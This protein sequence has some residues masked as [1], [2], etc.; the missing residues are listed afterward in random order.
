M[1]LDQVLERDCGVITG[2]VREAIKDRAASNARVLFWAD[3][4]YRIRE[5]SQVVIKAN[6]YEVL[7]C[8]TPLP[9]ERVDEEALIRAAQA[10]RKRSGAP[11][12]VTR[13]ADGM[14][15]SDPLWTRIPGVPIAG[16]IDPTGAGD[17][18][19]AG[20][21]L[22]LCAGAT[23]PE[24]ALV[25]NLVAAITIRQIGTTGTAHPDQLAAALDDWHAASA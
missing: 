1:I 17:S 4:R 25:G 5:F 20:A 15:V 7:E 22:A 23:L 16:E 19:S 11:V 12:V 9:G 14:M 13:G 21:V 6:Q 18:A 10:L 3:S 24:A 8:G 2:R